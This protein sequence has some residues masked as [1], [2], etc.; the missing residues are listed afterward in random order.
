MEKRVVKIYSNDTQLSIDTVK[1][2]EQ[3][4]KDAGFTIAEEFTD[5]CELLICVGG[6]GAFLEAVHMYGFPNIP[7]IGINTGH[8]GFFQEM[9]SD[10]LDLFI[11]HYLARK[12]KIQTLNTVEAYVTLPHQPIVLTGLNEIV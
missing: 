10:D 6:D 12:Y 5:E 11:E 2:L 8:L 7:I 1:I 9:P 4:L 3:K